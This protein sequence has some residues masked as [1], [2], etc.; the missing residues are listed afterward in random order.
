[1]KGHTEQDQKTKFLENRIKFTM[2][3]TTMQLIKLCA[4]H[5]EGANKFDIR[6]PSFY[7]NWNIS[8]T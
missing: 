3:S 7:F 4:N 1:M 6:L 5:E 2:L 8:L